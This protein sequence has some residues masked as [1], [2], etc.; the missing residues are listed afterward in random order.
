[1]WQGDEAVVVVV[2]KPTA[3]NQRLAR[4]H[5]TPVWCMLVT[6][7]AYPRMW[8]QGSFVVTGG[9]DRVLRYWDL[10]RPVDS[11]RVSSDDIGPFDLRYN[12]RI[13]NNTVGRGQ[14]RVCPGRL[15]TCARA[16]GGH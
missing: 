1:M 10:A 6:A 8:L 9:H 16:A 11:Y 15:L 14:W 7:A 5:G 12:A 4:V 13:E 2:R 3:C